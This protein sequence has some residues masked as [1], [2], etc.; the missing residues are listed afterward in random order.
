[1]TMR[2]LGILLGAAWGAATAAGAADAPKKP[3][4]DQADF[5]LVMTSGNSEGTNFALTNKFKYAW[6]NAEL[7]FDA[8]ALRTESTTRTLTNP[9]GVVV[10]LEDQKVTAETYAIG[11]KYRRNI[12]ERLFWYVGASWYQNFFSGV[13]DRY[14]GGGGIGYVFVTTPR[15]LFKGEAGLDWTY[16]QPLYRLESMRPPRPPE[17]DTK[18]YGGGRVTL[19]YEFKISAT[20]KLTEDLNLFESLKDSSDWRA[21]SAT[22]VTA[23]LTTHLA[24]K[25]SYN[26]LY[27][28]QP[29]FSVVPPDA[30]APPGTPSA[31]YE[32]K[33]TDT[34]LAAAL[35]VNF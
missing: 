11:A 29:A 24:L 13:D 22:A 21:N 6:S 16:E 10:V 5:G 18:S 28:N 35:V 23:S 30:T 12:S 8:A 33:K 31:L 25:F 3:W 17:L 34:I 20:A 4:A 19:G 14:I 1:M 15:H 26:V 32:F 7:T 27:T 9:A 2:T